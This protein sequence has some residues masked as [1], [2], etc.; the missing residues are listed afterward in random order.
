M[1]R[2]VQVLERAGLASRRPHE[3]DGRS[4]LVAPTAK[5][6]RTLRRARGRRIDLLTE[7]L[8]GLDDAELRAVA[9]AAE[10]VE[11]LF[12]SADRPWRPL[13]RAS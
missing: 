1:T 2:T 4:S 8:A 11:R 13:T 9:H 7:A 12:G 6:V 10:T 5:G 3:S